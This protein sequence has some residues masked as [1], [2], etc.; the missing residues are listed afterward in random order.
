MNKNKTIAFLSLGIALY[1][2][3]SIAAV[4]PIVNRIKLDLGYIVF[5][6][7]LNAFGIP[8]TIVGVAGCIISNLLKGG[9]FRIAWVI[10]QAF[11]GITLGYLLPRTKS[12]LLKIA[13]A[14]VSVFIGIAL[15]KTVIECAMYSFPFDLKFASNLAAFAVDA[16]ALVI[17]ILL[18]KRIKIR[19]R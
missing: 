9:S 19:N 10:G 14:V 12:D 3:L 5:G 15:I 2:A 18:S 4:I 1:V 13:Y 8:A 17:G 16:I 6:L 7:Y 11:I